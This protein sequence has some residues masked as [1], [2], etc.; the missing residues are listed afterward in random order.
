MVA[1]LRRIVEAK[2]I[3][4]L[5][6][7]I[8]T[9]A[10]GDDGH[11]IG[12]LIDGVR[13]DFEQ[14]WNTRKKAGIAKQFGDAVNEHNKQEQTKVFKALIG[15]DPAEP[16]VTEN[17]D[18]FVSEN[19]RLITSVSE[20]ALSQIEGIINNAARTGARIEET[21]DKIRERLDVSASR[22]QLI[23]RDQANKLYGSLT[24]ERQTATGVTGYI[25]RTSRDERVR[26]SHAVLEGE[27]FQWDDPPSVGHPGEDF[28]CRCTAEPDIEGLLNSLEGD[29]AS[30]DGEP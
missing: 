5:G 8:R 12:K 27:K 28:N 11:P 15:I 30:D 7:W 21:A 18:L 25:R 13:Y 26:P 29:D 1:D 19:V 2:V 10:A 14:E 23:A 3:P 6:R 22:A 24:K 4:A 16:N 9:D 20:D 17:L